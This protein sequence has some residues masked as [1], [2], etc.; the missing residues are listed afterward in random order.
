MILVK[1][2]T[3]HGERLPLQQ[4]GFLVYVSK[5]FQRAT[6]HAYST[7][8]YRF[9]TANH[10]K[11]VSVIWIWFHKHFLEAVL[12]HEVFKHGLLMSQQVVS[13]GFPTTENSQAEDVRRWWSLIH[14]W[15]TKYLFIK[16]QQDNFTHGTLAPFTITTLVSDCHVKAFPAPTA[17]DV[18]LNTW[19]SLTL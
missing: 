5:Q 7:N 19:T 9:V 2:S 18:N 15:Q 17:K 6:L 16:I 10:Q 12:T 14:S 11:N 13:N 3:E 8:K 4:H 1:F